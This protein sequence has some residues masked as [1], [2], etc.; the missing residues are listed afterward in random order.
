LVDGVT[1]HVGHMLFPDLCDAVNLADL[2]VPKARLI[3]G[4]SPPFPIP[5]FPYRVF[6]LAPIDGDPADEMHGFPFLH[7][8]GL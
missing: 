8:V 1:Q 4:A 2:V 5:D 6:K 7:D 3:H